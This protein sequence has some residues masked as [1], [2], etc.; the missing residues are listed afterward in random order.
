MRFLRNG[1]NGIYLKDNHFQLIYLN[2]MKKNDFAILFSNS[3]ETSD[4]LYCAK[5]L[6][7]NNIKF[8]CI[9]SSIVS[10]LAKISDYQ[11][12]IKFIKGPVTSGN[13]ITQIVQMYVAD[14]INTGVYL[15]DKNKIMKSREITYDYATA[16]Q[17]G[18]L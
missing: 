6:K 15:Q 14:L 18:D 10:S 2:E 9:T 12:L 8:L 7:E 1:L 5:I 13:M 16:K 11:I 17:K 3:G 4:V